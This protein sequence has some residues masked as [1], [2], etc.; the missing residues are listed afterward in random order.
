MATVAAIQAQLDATGRGAT[1]VSGP[2][3][4]TSGTKDQFLVRGGADLTI[5]RARKVLVEVNRG[6]TAAQQAT[7]ML[8]ALQTFR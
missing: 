8:A 4:T 7:A 2:L 5:G 1:I 3:F 6:D